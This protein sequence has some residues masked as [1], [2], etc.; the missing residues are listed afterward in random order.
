VPVPQYVPLLAA[1]HSGQR[2]ELASTSRPPGRNLATRRRS[3]APW[4]GGVHQPEAAVQH[5]IGGFVVA[6]EHQ[7]VPGQRPGEGA[8]VRAAEL[9][10]PVAGTER[11]PLDEPVEGGGALGGQRRRFQTDRVPPAA[12]PGRPAGRSRQSAQSHIRSGV[13]RVRAG[14]GERRKVLRGR[15]RAQV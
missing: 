3:A 7:P 4:F 14:I 10:H 11:T 12:G 9:G 15:L 8:A 6:G 1:Q 5:D 2:V 13:T